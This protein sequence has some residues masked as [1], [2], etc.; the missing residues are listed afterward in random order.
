[1]AVVWGGWGGES[2]KTASLARETARLAANGAMPGE[3]PA[4][5][6]PAETCAA[7]APAVAARGGR[8]EPIHRELN[9]YFR[10]AA[11]WE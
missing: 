6:T 8:W 11:R 4:A 2:K 5:G 10:F 3:S 7:A 1:M 9:G